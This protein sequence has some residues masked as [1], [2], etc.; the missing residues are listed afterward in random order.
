[1]L[2]GIG[3]WIIQVTNHPIVIDMPS[4][5]TSVNV[6]VHPACTSIRKGCFE[7]PLQTPHSVDTQWQMIGYPFR[8]SRKIDKIRVVTTGLPSVCF[9]GCTLKRSQ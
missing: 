4:E 6:R 8:D 1:M 2:P 3:Y 9:I 5:S 7:I